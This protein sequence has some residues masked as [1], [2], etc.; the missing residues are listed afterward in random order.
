MNGTMNV[1]AG[2]SGKE[3]AYFLLR[4]LLLLIALPIPD[5]GPMDARFGFGIQFWMVCCWITAIVDIKVT[6]LVLTFA[7]CIYEFML[8]GKVLEAYV[9]HEAALILGATAIIA[10]WNRWGFARRLALNFLMLD[11]GIL[12]DFMKTN[13]ETFGGSKNF[14]HKEVEAL[15]PMTFKEKISFCGFVFPIMRAVLQALY[16]PYL[17]GPMKEWLKSIQMSCII[18]MLPFFLLREAQYHEGRT[19]NFCAS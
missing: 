17:N 5:F 15:G 3:F 12:M 8:L 10:A 7:A 1:S 2:Y 11:V 4:P 14:H 16:A 9:P 13:R 19:F 6:C 18:P